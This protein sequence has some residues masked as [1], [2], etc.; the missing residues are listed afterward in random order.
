MPRQFGVAQREALPNDSERQT[1]LFWNRPRSG[2]GA[3]ENL[4]IAKQTVAEIVASAS[5]SGLVSA[6]HKLRENH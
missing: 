6:R 1:E 5:L 2:D 4:E 3:P